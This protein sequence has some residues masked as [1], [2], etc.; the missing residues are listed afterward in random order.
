MRK[1]KSWYCGCDCVLYFNPNVIFYS[2]FCFWERSYSTL[3]QMEIGKRIEKAEHTLGKFLLLGC[4]YPSKFCSLC[5]CWRSETSK[6]KPFLI[7]HSVH[8]KIMHNKSLFEPD[9]NFMVFRDFL[10][11]QIVVPAFSGYEL[12]KTWQKFQ[13]VMMIFTIGL[14]KHNLDTSYNEII[15]I[16]GQVKRKV[17]ICLRPG[18]HLKT[19]IQS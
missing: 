4:C 17:L 16:I 5:K 19:L 12:R 9:N 7:L 10:F 1:W 14:D 8:T 11:F 6:I 2:F 15:I 13:L 3:S 18:L